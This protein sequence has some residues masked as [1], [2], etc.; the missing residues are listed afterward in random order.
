[1]PKRSRR[2]DVIPERVLLPDGEIQTIML[3][4][5]YAP[6][7]SQ[8]A[9]IENLCG[10]FSEYVEGGDI[11][12]VLI[13]THNRFG[14]QR[15][16]FNI[17]GNASIHFGKATFRGVRGAQGLEAMAKALALSNASNTVHMAVICGKIGKRVQV[18]SSGLLETILVNRF[19]TNMRVIGRM[20]DHNNTVRLVVSRFEDG[21][22]TDHPV[23][24]LPRRYWP[25]KNDWAVT[26]R[27]TVMARFTWK[28]RME[29]TPECE[30]EILAIFNRVMESC[31]Q[32]PIP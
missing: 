24:R 27:G 14:R 32:T 4:E 25:C 30:T 2:S 10:S 26:G 17:H 23:F 12:P 3:D 5:R 21:V 28:R 13:T 6:Y 7:T 15:E 9:S 18:T 29:W 16:V 8:A 11:M 1:M 19:A 20:Y 22:E 31:F